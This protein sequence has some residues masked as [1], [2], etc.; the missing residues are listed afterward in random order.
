M[1][2]V[3]CFFFY[4]NITERFYFPPVSVVEAAAV[5]Q[6]CH[7]LTYFFGCDIW[8]FSLFS[9]QFSDLVVLLYAIGIPIMACGIVY[10]SYKYYYDSENSIERQLDGN[11]NLKIEDKGLFLELFHGLMYLI[12]ILLWCHYYNVNE[13][14]KFEF[15]W[16]NLMLYSGLFHRLI[17]FK[18]TKRRNDQFIHGIMVPLLIISFSLSSQWLLQQ[19]GFLQQNPNIDD[20]YDYDYVSFLGEYLFV[21]FTIIWV[22]VAWIVFAVRALTELSF[23]LQVNILRV[24]PRLFGKSL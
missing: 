17:I 18:I 1:V 5:L 22:T 14:F 20:D 11:T 2:F 24:T 4:C 13:K 9:Y 16:I 23:I 21:Y 15:F 7:L 19:F 6:I 8:Q 3:W 10:K 12:T